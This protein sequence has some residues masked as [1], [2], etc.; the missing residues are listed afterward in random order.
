MPNQAANTTQARR[1]ELDA[2]SWS[3]YQ[4]AVEDECEFGTGN[5]AV[6]AVAGSG[7]TTTIEWLTLTGAVSGRVLVCAFNKHI[8]TPM[9]KLLGD[10]AEVRT[11]NAHGNA[12]T[13]TAA[14]QKSWSYLNSGK[15]RGYLNEDIRAACRGYSSLA[16][17]LSEHWPLNSAVRVVDL[18]RSTMLATVSRDKKVSLSRH[19]FNHI[20]SNWDITVDS[21]VEN[22]VYNAT[23]RALQRGIDEWKTVI[24]F[25][26]QNWLPVSL[27]L[28]PKK[29]DWVIVDEAQD[30]NQMQLQYVMKCLDTNG[31][32]L[33][34][35]D[36]RQA[37]YGFSGAMHDSFDQIVRVSNA[38]V[39]PLSICYRCPTSHLDMAR[40]IVPHLEAR[41]DAPEGDI[42]MIG[43]SSLPTFVRDKDLILCRVNA[44]LIKTAYQLLA[45]GIAARIRGGDLGK[46][47]KADIKKVEKLPNYTWARFDDGLLELQ[48]REIDTIM[49]RN[50]GNDEDPA[51]ARRRDRTQCL[52]FI[53]ANNPECSSTAC[54]AKAIDVLFDESNASVTLSSVHKAKGDQSDRVLIFDPDI[55][56]HPMAQRGPAWQMTQ[57]WNIKYVALTRAKQ[58]LILINPDA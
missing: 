48:T 42:Q 29:Y 35:G 44:P 18:A 19:D 14:N 49:R 9:S 37:M 46:S 40:E 5:I 6:D 31:R 34:V 12:T 52:L 58:S 23:V 30:L 28:Q 33:A 55:M 26:D 38:K 3:P 47:L 15:Y 8:A 13:K 51:I 2:M 24:D 39:L 17:A 21:S 41:P 4:L 1:A 22:W 27:N 45:Q 53:W 20:V 16:D 57:E 32:L 36:P 56:P 43:A 10:H 50:G 25:C 7:K 54:L 11:I